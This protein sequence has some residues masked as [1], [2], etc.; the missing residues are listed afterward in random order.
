MPVYWLGGLALVVSFGLG[1]MLIRFAP[2]LQLVQTPNQRS[3]HQRPTPTGGGIA[4]LGGGIVAA[5]FVTGD[6]ALMSAVG[7]AM[8]ALGLWDDLREPPAPLRLV[9]HTA[10][11]AAMVLIVGPERIAGLLGPYA[12]FVV[13]VGAVWWIN[14]FNF[15]DGIDGLAAGQALFMLAGG[16]VIVF[17]THENWA[18]ET[19][20]VMLVALGAATLGFLALNLPPARIFMGGVGSYFLATMIFAL[21]LATLLQGWV[22]LQS[23]LILGAAFVSDATVTLLTRVLRREKFWRAHRSHAYQR[24]ARTWGGHGRVT[25][26]FATINILYLLPLAVLAQAAPIFAWGITAFAYGPLL[27]AAQQFGAGRPDAE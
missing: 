24:I 10:A 15:M 13:G 22:S 8:A 4:I 1:L 19:E 23:W 5:P 26:V 25:A 12:P 2:F 7:L 17:L 16:V 3:S 9:L 27:V 20:T 14:L 18:G 21:A 6:L 11:A